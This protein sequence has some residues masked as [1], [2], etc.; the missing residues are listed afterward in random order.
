MAQW[1]NNL[2]AIC[3]RGICFKLIAAHVSRLQ[4]TPDPNGVAVREGGEGGTEK[5]GDGTLEACGN[6]LG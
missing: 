1:V 6:T 2:L 5:R 4:H 3:D